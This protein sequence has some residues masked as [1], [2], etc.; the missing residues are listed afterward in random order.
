MRGWNSSYELKCLNDADERAC[1]CGV[2]P[3]DVRESVPA[4]IIPSFSPAAAEE[5]YTTGTWP[6]VYITSGG[7]GGFRRKTYLKDMA[8]RAVEDLWF[9]MEVGSNDEAKNEIKA[10]FPGDTP[11]STPKPERLLERVIHIGTNPGDIVLDCFAGSGT[12]AAVAQKMGRRWVTCE[13]LESTFSAFTRPRLEKVIND[14]DPGGVTANKP[15][16]V[17]AEGVELPDGVSPDD[18]ARFTSVLN[19]LIAND[20]DL[21]DDNAVKALK[22]MAKT[23]NL[24]GVVNWRG[25]GGFQVAHLAPACFDYDPELDRVVLTEAATGELLVR[26]VAANLGFAM[27]PDCE[28]GTFDARRGKTLLKVYEGIADERLVDDLVAQLSDGESLVIAATGVADGARERLRRA[29]RGSQ[30]VHVPDGI[31]SY[32]KGVGL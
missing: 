16:R 25:G 18:A 12:T 28:R 22:R 17:A 1:V 6:L 10:L 32:S 26:S 20:P 3:S 24:K 19:K 9:Q 7:R 30:V 2:A 14:E 5:L 11:F 8:D 13:L 31:F 4:L 29:R 23:R 27:L 21:K 15:E